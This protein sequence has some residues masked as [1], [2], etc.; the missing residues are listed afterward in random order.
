MAF[1]KIFSRSWIVWES[2]YLPYFRTIR[3]YTIQ[4][5]AGLL[6]LRFLVRMSCIVN[7]VGSYKNICR[8]V[9]SQRVLPAMFNRNMNNSKRTPKHVVNSI[10]EIPV[11][12][13]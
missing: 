5:H 10:V 4:R 9:C 6:Y 1:T 7:W 2:E 13:N 11:E 3:K 12:Q 8:Q